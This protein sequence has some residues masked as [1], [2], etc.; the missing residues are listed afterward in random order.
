MYC[1]HSHFQVQSAPL[2]LLAMQLAAEPGK[3][4][5]LR[6]LQP[7]NKWRHLSE[8]LNPRPLDWDI[9]F[10]SQLQSQIVGSC[11]ISEVRW[12]G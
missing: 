3:V 7:L 8:F 12:K 11:A 5:W 6:G 4:T 2:L 1:E 10:K 9:L